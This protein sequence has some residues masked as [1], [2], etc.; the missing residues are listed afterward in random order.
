MRLAAVR[1]DLLIICL[2][3]LL[4]ACVNS[5]KVTLTGQVRDAY[6]NKPVEGAQVTIGKESGIAT[7]AQ[8]RWATQHWS[9][10]DKALLQATGYESAS[11]NL[12]TWPA[13]KKSQALTLTAE[14]SS[15][16]TGIPWTDF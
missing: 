14:V 6:T 4:A 12:A 3:L 15:Q 7:D 10:S 5:P 11:L 8:G 9:M 1:R 13:L 16:R 2:G